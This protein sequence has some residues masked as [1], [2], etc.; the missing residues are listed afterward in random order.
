MALVKEWESVKDLLSQ[1]PE[2]SK[3]LVQL[4][5]RMNFESLWE[6]LTQALAQYKLFPDIDE[7]VDTFALCLEE[8]EVG[9]SKLEEAEEVAHESLWLIPTF[10]DDLRSIQ[11]R[12]SLGM[13]KEKVEA[14]FNQYGR[15][16]QSETEQRMCAKLGLTP[17]ALYA[18]LYSAT[19]VS[20]AEEVKE[21][22]ARAKIDKF[23]GAAAKKREEEE[24]RRRR[25]SAQIEEASFKHAQEQRVGGIG[26]FAFGSLGGNESFGNS[27]SFGI[28][29]SFGGSS[30][31]PSSSG[32]SIPSS[33]VGVG[34]AFNMGG[35]TSPAQSTKIAAVSVKAIP[36]KKEAPSKVPVR[37]AEVTKKSL[38]KN[39][40]RSMPDSSSSSGSDSDSDSDSSSDSDSDSSSGLPKKSSKKA[41]AKKA[42]V[43][44][45][46]TKKASPPSKTSKVASKSTATTSSK[47]SKKVTAT[48]KPNAPIFS[49]SDASETP[50]LDGATS[51]WGILDPSTKIANI[52]VRTL[53]GKCLS[54]DQVLTPS[55][56]VSE[57]MQLIEKREGIPFGQMRLIF[58]GKLM[59]HTKT[60]GDY[61]CSHGCNIHLVL[62]L[63]SDTTITP[64]AVASQTST[65]NSAATQTAIMTLPAAAT[66]ASSSSSTSSMRSPLNPSSNTTAI[67][68]NPWTTHGSVLVRGAQ[69][70]F[71]SYQSELAFSAT[72]SSSSSSSSSFSSSFSFASSPSPSSSSL[73]SQSVKIA[74]FDMDQTLINVKSGAKFPRDASDW[75]W[76]N[77]Y[78][79]PQ[80]LAL[81]S[82]GYHIVI[83]TNQAGISSGQQK[84]EDIKGKIDAI[85]KELGE[86]APQ[87]FYTTPFGANS[88]VSHLKLYALVATA[89]DCFRKPSP[90]LWHLFTQCCLSDGNDDITPDLQSSFFVG[91]AA[92]RHKKDHSTA[93]RGFAHNVGLKYFTEDTFFSSA[94]SASLIPSTPSDDLYE[95]IF[96]LYGPSGSSHSI[97]STRGK[98]SQL[99]QDEHLLSFKKE[100]ARLYALQNPSSS[101]S[102]SS[103]TS[104]SSSPSPTSFSSTSTHPLPLAPSSSQE[105]L[106]VSGMPGSGKTTLT[107]RYTNE[108]GYA[109]VNLDTLRSAAQVTEK[110]KAFLDQGR[111]LVIDQTFPSKDSRAPYVAM[112][113]K[114][115]IPIR[116]ICFN[117]PRSVAV[118]LN[119]IRNW[120]LGQ[121]LVPQIAYHMF[122]KNYQTPTEAEGFS[123][124]L[125]LPFTPLLSSNP[126]LHK[127]LLFFT[128]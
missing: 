70:P 88:A 110:A 76:A 15:K 108:A 64:V 25:I 109:S 86:V 23:G 26:S 42:P 118:H 79:K 97:F 126:L 116:I 28:S 19:N 102:S 52:N 62:R 17:T 91:D 100:I 63:R 6:P 9:A 81:I 65:E 103:L 87:A 46:P 93:D 124:V 72:P 50:S 85:A 119:I 98:L 4:Y 11:R 54:F 106:L 120:V 113:A 101:F 5:G 18:S 66:P 92:G 49:F 95:S 74:A 27:Q 75:K 40:S 30:S 47:P 105:I 114:R 68:L 10:N 7:F 14:S 45:V 73:S 121:P 83:F 78:V 39:R 16:S 99:T 80:L 84:A 36:A 2:G 21:R 53:T 82:A 90:C 31:F 33:P 1:H 29:P 94:H 107:S 115:G 117:T 58:A 71:S 41:P 61:R 8:M 60:L 77:E 24:E 69:K 51:A 43:K 38:F 22:L 128:E 34:G 57:L 48:K 123:T 13:F 112:A 89:K 67:P 125:S 44:K 122:E 12:K 104:F 35:S 111:S 55:S 127:S 56:Y 3:L 96:D 59:D 20:E 32:S 37:K